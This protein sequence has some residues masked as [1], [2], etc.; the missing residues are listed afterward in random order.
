MKIK[1]HY[2]LRNIAGEYIVIPRG[3]ATL[4]FQ[5][6]IVLNETGAYLWKL[7]VEPVTEDALVSRMIVEYDVPRDTAAAD[8]A[9]FIELLRE[10]G[11]IEDYVL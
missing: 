3:R 6:T 4:D 1:D 11:I 2:V 7:M 10:N 9:K 5:A 8:V